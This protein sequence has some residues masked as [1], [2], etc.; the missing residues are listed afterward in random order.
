MA[1]SPRVRTVRG[2]VEDFLAGLFPHPIAAVVAAALAA[3]ASIPLVSFAARRTLKQP[4]ALA[5]EA[6]GLLLAGVLGDLR[7][8]PYVAQVRATDFAAAHH[9]DIWEAL[10][11]ALGENGV[12]GE[13]ADADDCARIGEQLAPHRSEVL[14][15]VRHLLA[16]A[17][18]QPALN[19]ARFEELVAGVELSADVTASSDALDVATV[20][21]AEEVIACGNDRNRLSGSGLVVPTANPNSTST[22]D[23]PLARAAT[24]TTRLRGAVTALVCAA[25]AALIPGWLTVFPVTGAAWVFALVSLVALG[26]MSVAVSLVDLDTLYIDVPVW[27]AG[28]GLAWAAAIAS[29][30][31]AGDPGRILAGLMMVAII[32]ISLEGTNLLFRLV[33]GMD[34]QG[35]GDTLLIIATVGV[36]PVLASDY[37]VGFWSVFAGLVI[38]GLGWFAARLAGRVHR[39]EPFAFGPWLSVGWVVACCWLVYDSVFMLAMR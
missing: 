24:P 35:F 28:T 32:G 11:R 36:P 31:A 30:L 14:D 20:T 7:R 26:A 29:A 10:V 38:G 19:L 1:A 15:Q 27:A 25:G 22:D 16:T 18:S 4:V 9:H 3:L 6:E 5:L 12:I 17:S 37:R 2:M 39:K 34:G 23:P 13:N 8:W 33:R 21:A